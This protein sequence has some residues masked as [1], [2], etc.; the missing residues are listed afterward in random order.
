MNSNKDIYGYD[1]LGIVLRYLKIPIVFKNKYVC[2]YFVADILKRANVYN[3]DKE[4]Y[5]IKPRDFSLIDDFNLI[6]SGKYLMYR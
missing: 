4:T 3:F 5:F 6:Y 2:S 1:Y